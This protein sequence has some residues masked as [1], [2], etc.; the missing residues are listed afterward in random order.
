VVLSG[1]FAAFSGPVL[2]DPPHQV[3]GDAD[4]EHPVRLVAQYVNP[5][6]RHVPKLRPA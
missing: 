3:G 6:S 4:V 5:A 1:K 2:R